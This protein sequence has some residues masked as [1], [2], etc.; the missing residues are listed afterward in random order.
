MKCVNCQEEIGFWAA[1]KH[2]TPFRVKC[3][4]CKATLKVSTPFMA[5]IFVGSLFLFLVITVVLGLAS[6]A[7]LSTV[8]SL[9]KDDLGP[10][11]DSAQQTV[12]TVR[13][14]T[15]FM[16][17]KAVSPI[18]GANARNICTARMSA[19]AREISCPV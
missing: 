6:R 14:T 10:L 8:R 17:E 13:G 18:S 7:L 15:A 5:P 9:L 3:S 11:L 12:Q 4:S 16:G 1:L 2:V 19:F